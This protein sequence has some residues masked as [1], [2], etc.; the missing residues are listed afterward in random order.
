MILPERMQ[1]LWTR[2]PVCL[3]LAKVILGIKTVIYLYFLIV[4]FSLISLLQYH[5]LLESQRFRTSIL[6]VFCKLFTHT[7]CLLNP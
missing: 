1:T 5:F 2:L 6:V 4:C 7:L 3:S